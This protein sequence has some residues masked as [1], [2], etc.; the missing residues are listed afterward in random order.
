MFQL[1]KRVECYLHL[2]R[3]RERDVDGFKKCPQYPMRNT[4]LNLQNT[5]DGL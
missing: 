3:E 2:K 1:S 5:L 4:F